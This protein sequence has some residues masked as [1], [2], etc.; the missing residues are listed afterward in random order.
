MKPVRSL[1]NYVHQISSSIGFIPS[2]LSILFLFLAFVM[3]KVDYSGIGDEFKKYIFFNRLQDIT[4]I[5]AIMTTLIS[6]T[7][8]L[9]I[10]SFSM[11]MIVLN[12][13]SIALSPKLLFGIVSKR[14]HQYV[15]GVYIGSVIYFIVIP[16]GAKSGK[17]LPVLSVLLAI[18]VG[19]FSLSLFVL[20]IHTISNRIQVNNIIS[21]IFENTKKTML[22]SSEIDENKKEEYI[23]ELEYEFPA[24]ETGYLQK[25]DFVKMQ[26]IAQEL[27]LVIKMEAYETAYV[28]E[29]FPIFYMNKKYRDL[30]EE[31][32]NRINKLFLFYSGEKISDNFSYGFTQLM[33]VAIKAMSPGINDPGTAVYCINY[34]NELFLLLYNFEPKMHYYD[35]KGELRISIRSLNFID[36]LNRCIIPIIRYGGK[37]ISVTR[38]LLLFLYRLSQ[39][40]EINQKLKEVLNDHAKSIIIRI[41]SELI[42]NMEINALDQIIKRMNKHMNNY[43]VLEELK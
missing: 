16:L 15:L 41:K 1:K 30:T 31:Q 10:L 19:L 39:K 29:G 2:V 13:V 40:D 3:L 6:G 38:A 22:K 43:F 12:Q 14:S 37:D 33:E 17:E 24:A 8:S 42:S 21:N 5:T 32:I 27:D 11:V 9:M 23:S 35:S 25:I 20:F 18:L 28:A 26:T 34:L 4:S 36:L 7:I